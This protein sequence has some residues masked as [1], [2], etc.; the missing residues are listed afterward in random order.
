MKRSVHP[1][2]SALA[3]M[4]LGIAPRAGASEQ[5]ERFVRPLIAERCRPCHGPDR[6]EGS[7]RLDSRGALL[8]GGSTGAAVTPGDPGRSL[9]VR[10]LGGDAAAGGPHR[11][12]LTPGEIGAI[13]VWIAAGAPWPGARV[14]S[15]P[16]GKA[17]D[18]W[19]FQPLRRPP[20]PGNPPGAES[21][22][23]T[24]MTTPCGAPASRP[25]LPPPAAS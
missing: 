14:A 19:A 10:V 9:L 16:A 1:V 4:I 11:G 17:L 7:L 24:F 23:D 15:G 5:F 18:W 21:P 2:W 25:R 13:E 20:V 6:A 12:L 8:T 22:I 3:A